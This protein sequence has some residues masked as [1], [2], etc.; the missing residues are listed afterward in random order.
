MG[1][2]LRLC[3][4]LFA[5]LFSTAAPVVAQTKGKGPV[6]DN[7]RLARRSSACAMLDD[8][9]MARWEKAEP[10][11]R[12]M[13]TRI[14]AERTGD[15]N[16][17]APPRDARAQA[18]A[19]GSP[20]NSA[21]TPPPALGASY[22]GHPFFILRQDQYDQATYI[23]QLQEGQ[24]LQGASVSYTK[25]H[26]ANTQSAT[27]KGLLGV[28]A[29]NGLIRA[30]CDNEANYWAR[31]HDRAFLNGYGI[32]AFVQGNGTYNQPTNANEKSALRMGLDADFLFC[33][34]PFV[35][36]QE[37]QLMPYFQTDF[38]GRANIAGFDSLWELTDTS[39]HL[40]GRTDVPKSKLIGFY[41]RVVGEANLFDVKNAG[42][43]NY[44]PNTTHAFLGGR[45][46]LR[47]VLF[48]NNP[49]VWAPLCGRISLV[50]T[51]QYLWDAVSQKP[52]YLYGGEVGYNLTLGPSSSNC[53]GSGSDSPPPPGPT[54]SI[55]FSYN[56]GTDPMTS[57]KQNVYKG[58][59]KLSY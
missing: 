19:I 7:E 5:V 39:I 1:S 35:P 56:Q 17:D 59:L 46:E 44:L 15:R 23:T 18:R 24:I 12:V 27:V 33:N 29:Y 52:V 6:A 45:T 2:N 8:P 40:G 31:Q 51:A 54:G 30:P 22:I 57:V 11:L 50:G 55:S 41:Y 28:S 36:L 53:Q 49:D 37:F 34:T 13:L 47:A 42:L 48:E 14:C 21:V 43:T 25:D 10:G 38:R 32:G 4:S 26:L 9:S 16:F 3:I 20:P 58:S